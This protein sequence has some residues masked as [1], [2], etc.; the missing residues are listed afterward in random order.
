[1]RGAEHETIRPGQHRSELVAPEE[2]IDPQLLRPVGGIGPPHRP[3][4][5]A[6][7]LRDASDLPADATRPD[8]CH[9]LASQLAG[10]EPFPVMRALL[11]PEMTE[12][13]DMPEEHAEHEFGERLSV[14][15][16]CCRDDEIAALKPEPL[17]DLP[18]PGGGRLHPSRI[19]GD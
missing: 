1:M 17:H 10:G 11:R 12:P 13:L 4:V 9:G 15:A 18:D 8:D 7:C 5:H 6:K 14:D 3:D 2:L 19:G 16:T